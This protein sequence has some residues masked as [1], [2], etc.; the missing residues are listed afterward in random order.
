MWGFSVSLLVD[1]FVSLQEGKEKKK[2][3]KIRTG[4]VTALVSEKKQD[5]LSDIST[6]ILFLLQSL[7]PQKLTQLE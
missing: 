1:W 2:K 7:V 6:E 3:K 4:E 5:S